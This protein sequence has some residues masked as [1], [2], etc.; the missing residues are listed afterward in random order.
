MIYFDNAATTGKK[1][2][3]VINAVNFALKELS[4]N[5]GRSGHKLSIKTSDVIYKTREKIS[6][7]FGGAGAENV[8]FTLNCTHSINCVLKGVLKKGDHVVVSNL[9]HNA[10]MR[11]L[12]KMGVN[13]DV[14]QVFD[15]DERTI[16]SFKEKIKV[17]TKLVVVTGASNVTGEI[18]PF[19]EIGKICNERGVYFCLDAA[20]IAGVIPINMT[21]MNIDFLCIAPHKGIYSPMG[22][23]VLVCRK[24]IENTIIEGGTGSSSIDFLQPRILPEMLESGT[25][26]VPA[27]LG[28]SSGID[29]LKQK[30]IENIYKHEFLLTKIAYDGLRKNKNIILYTKTPEIYRTA[31]VIPFNFKDIPSNKTSEILNSFGIATRSGLHCAPTAHKSIGTLPSGAVRLS[32]SAFNNKNEVEYFLKVI[33]CK[34]FIK[35]TKFSIE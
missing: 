1:P 31:P 34:K 33:N 18:L 15:D 10:V 22:I 19:A 35:K 6:D 5:P 8:V 20:Q 16:I 13:F 24:E 3:S 14:A 32:F 27:I 4:A 21:Q 7:F 12:I 30:G 2:N 25:I 29:F 23:G 28:V 11:P 9:E 26:N 17:N